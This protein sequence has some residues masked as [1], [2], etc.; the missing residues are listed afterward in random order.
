MQTCIYLTLNNLRRIAL[1]DLTGSR[2]ELA[3]A[4]HRIAERRELARLLEAGRSIQ[5]PAPRRI[6]KTWLIKRLA[7]DL[8]A[9]GWVCISIDLQGMR[10]EQEFFR[11]LCQEIETRQDLHRS[12]LAHLREKFRHIKDGAGAASLV[13]LLSAGV[14][15]RAFSESLIESL[16]GDG[17]KTVVL[18]DEI[19]LFAQDLAKTNADSARAFLYHLRNLREAN[20]TVRWLFTGSIGL[21]VIAARFGLQG[22][23]IDMDIFELRPFD[24]DEA[25]AFVEELR[26]QNQLHTPFVF[27]GGAF[28]KLARELGWLSPWY[29]RLLVNAI[30]PTGRAAKS[31]LATATVA[32]VE[33]AIEKLLQPAQRG[34]FA[35]WREHLEKNFP[36]DQTAQLHA[37]LGILCENADGEQ[38]GTILARLSEPF[39]NTTRRELMDRLTDLA[40]GGFLEEAGD[41]WRFR[42]GLLRRYWAKWMK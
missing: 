9:A 2:H 38:A 10:T 24:E 36:K 21:E 3:K 31:G 1:R 26:E 4:H 7:E 20:R 42:S 25:R 15:P 34:H 19:S 13:Q 41:R 37:I 11:T 22:A 17:K 33:A 39:S 28:E 14:D 29:L 6:G 5:M 30:R 27:A 23:L 18:I 16:D 32:D 40:S 35:T 8:K 12:A